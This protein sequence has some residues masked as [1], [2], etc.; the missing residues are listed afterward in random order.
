MD[1]GAEIFAWR[2]SWKTTTVSIAFGEYFIGHNPERS[3]LFIS[4]SGGNA[5][6]ITADCGLGYNDKFPNREDLFHLH[7]AQLVAIL[8]SLKVGG[9]FVAKI[10]L[11]QNRPIQISTL[12]LI[13][14]HCDEMSLY[15]PVVNPQ[16]QEF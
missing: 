12:Y 2:G 5:D 15:K 11:P 4:S 13:Y 3:N 6:L 8:N 9:N 10:Y 7:Y 14:Q 1:K 16:S